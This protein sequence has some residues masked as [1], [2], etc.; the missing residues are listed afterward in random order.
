[1]TMTDRSLAKIVGLVLL[2]AGASWI[3][4]LI[5]HYEP[6][7][8]AGVLVGSGF[9][10]YLYGG[11][12]PEF[13]GTPTEETAIRRTRRPAMRKRNIKDIVSAVREATLC[14][15]GWHGKKRIQK[16]DG[17]RLPLLCPH[18]HLILGYQ[19]RENG[20]TK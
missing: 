5:H 8:S 16:F 4:S 17:G 6:W 13:P 19:S 14:K 1:M 15:A 3:G 11:R 10:L 12:A 20:M 9:M 2:M 7:V 18:C